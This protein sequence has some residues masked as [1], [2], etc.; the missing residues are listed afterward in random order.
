MGV[1]DELVDRQQL[2]R[3][4]PQR[5]E[6]LERRGVREPRVGAA[7]LLGD[8]GMAL[9]EPLHVDLVDDRLVPGRPRRPVVRP[10]EVRARH[11]ALGHVGARVEVVDR[12]VRV[13]EAVG[14]HRLVPVHLALD[15]GRVWVQQQLG[16]MA[17]QARGGLV[18]PVHAEPVALAGPVRRR[19]AVPDLRRPL[20]QRDARLRAVGLEQAQLDGVG[21]LREDGEVRPVPS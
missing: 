17:A 4:D 10:V 9:R 16:G 13:V 6:V 11:H 7:Q 14:E 12:A 15:R 1:L 21:H 8:P 20:G 5:L 3:G 19:V 18:G 2:H